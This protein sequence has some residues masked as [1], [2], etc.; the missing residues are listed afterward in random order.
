MFRS[1]LANHD[2]FFI[3]FNYKHNAR[4]TQLIKSL[5]DDDLALSDIDT[6]EKISV[7]LKMV[8]N[9]IYILY[10]IFES[11]MGTLGVYNDSNK[12]YY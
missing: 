9:K 6:I 11:V 7:I 8:D 5:A 10:K 2:W 4:K 1:G 12:V 3:P